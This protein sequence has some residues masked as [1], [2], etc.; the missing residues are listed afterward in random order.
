MKHYLSLLFSL[1]FFQLTHPMKNTTR[2]AVIKSLQLS[3]LSTNIQQKRT[4]LDVFKLFLINPQKSCAVIERFGKYNRTV[5]AGIHFKWPLIEDARDIGWGPDPKR[6]DLR[7]RVHDLPKQ[8]VITEDNVEMLIGGLVYYK[9]EENNPEKA[10][11]EIKNLPYAIEKLA[12]T[13]LRNIIGSMHFDKT[14]TSRDHINKILCSNLDGATD[15]WGAII[16]RVEL[17]E[18]TPP[19]EILRAMEKQ[20]TAE[21]ERRSTVIAAEGDR[22]AIIKRAEANKLAAILE[23][24]GIA[25]ARIKSAQAE[26]DAIELIKK[27]SGEEADTLEYIKTIE[28]IRTLPKITA[29]H[30]NKLIIIP[31]NMSPLAS[32]VSSAKELFGL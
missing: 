12:L 19:V 26:A 9:I 20:M 7:E 28:Y 15:K 32:T 2:K 24:E 31:H 30:D 13:T 6:I 10:V 4:F 1:L 27:A 3:Q 23:A 22:E 11:Y 16:T 5:G 17:Q 29:G 25:T 8:S 21:R 18:I 14:V